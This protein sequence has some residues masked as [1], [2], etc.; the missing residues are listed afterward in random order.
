MNINEGSEAGAMLHR[1]KKGATGPEMF[2][3][4]FWAGKKWK[5]EGKFYSIAEAKAEHP[6]ALKHAEGDLVIVQIVFR[7]GPSRN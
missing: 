5:K 6:N 3:G 1:I 4:L 2:T 7:D